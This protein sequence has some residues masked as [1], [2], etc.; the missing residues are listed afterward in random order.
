MSCFDLSLF[1]DIIQTVVPSGD[2]FIQYINN[3]FR[4]C[5]PA[6]LLFAERP[7]VATGEDFG[8]EVPRS[9]RIYTVYCIA[10]FLSFK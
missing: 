3:Y 1:N 7:D 4:F 8:I 10:L 2:I 5:L 6:R 9:L